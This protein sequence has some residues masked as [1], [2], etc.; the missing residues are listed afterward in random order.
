MNTVLKWYF[1]TIIIKYN[2]IFLKAVKCLFKYD[3]EKQI[4]KSNKNYSHQ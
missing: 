1:K 2:G 4:I 3:V